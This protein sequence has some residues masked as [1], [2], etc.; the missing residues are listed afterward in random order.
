M[1]AWTRYQ[2]QK[3]I[4]PFS[5]F[6]FNLRFWQI[7][8]VKRCFAKYIES[9]LVFGIFNIL[10]DI[11]WGVL[12]GKI[13][14]NLDLWVHSRGFWFRYALIIWAAK[15]KRIS[16]GIYRKNPVQCL[17]FTTYCT[18]Y[19]ANFPYRNKWKSH[20]PIF[21]NIGAWDF[22][23]FLYA[24]LG[25]ICGHFFLKPGHYKVKI[26]YIPCWFPVASNYSITATDSSQF[27]YTTPNL[28]PAF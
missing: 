2:T 27:T 5:F 18:K 19:D 25:A 28:F 16:F 17:D 21:S 8:V 11:L 7:K 9:T 6:S 22:H 20:A 3:K 24:H 10:M 4:Y 12:F 14:T 15:V 1:S 26:S 13:A 23:L